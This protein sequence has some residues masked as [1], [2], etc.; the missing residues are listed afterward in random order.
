MTKQLPAD[1]AMRLAFDSLRAEELWRSQ[2]IKWRLFGDDVLPAWVAD[3]DFP[4]APPI[5]RALSELLSRSDLG[6]HN[7]PLSPH[8]REAL[9][10]RMAERFAWQ[11]EPSRVIPLVN[12]V[13]G[14]DAAVLLH[15][16]PGDGVIVR[17][18][19]YPLR[20]CTSTRHVE[21]GGYRGRGCSSG[22]SA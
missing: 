22:S 12:V 15:S 14:L 9:V 17:T 16:R 13:Q 3:M 4:V 8:L 20:P 7:V 6:Y 2:R 19:I 10:S 5:Q 1:R 21:P 18:P 11:V